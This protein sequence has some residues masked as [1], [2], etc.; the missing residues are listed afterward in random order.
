MACIQELDSILSALQPVMILNHQYC[1]QAQ[2]QDNSGGD[3]GSHKS[4]ITRS[5][6]VAAPEAESQVMSVQVAA[7]TPGHQTASGM[8]KIW[9]D[10]ALM[11]LLQAPEQPSK[12]P[13]VHRSMWHRKA[14]YS[15]FG[16][17]GQ[18]GTEAQ[19]N[20]ISAK[21]LHFEALLSSYLLC[22]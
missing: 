2:F 21:M 22:R 8:V 20:P 9:N 15:R 10:P 7:L 11:L 16:S 3:Y 5:C 6:L 13:T 18:V 17:L 1:P 4:R 12:P 19:E 14:D